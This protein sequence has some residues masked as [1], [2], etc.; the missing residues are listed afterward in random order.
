MT[1]EGIL[2]YG[3]ASGRTD[4]VN[5]ARN[6]FGQAQLLHGTR[7]GWLP[8]S[9]SFVH[10]QGCETDTMTAQTEMAFLLARKVDDA[11]WE[12]AEQIALNQ[13]LAQQLR[14]VDFLDD[15]MRLLGGFASFCSPHDWSTPEGPYITQSSHGSG[16]RSLYNVWYHSAWWQQGDTPGE[17]D[18][19][20]RINLHWSKNL[21]DAR[22]ISYLP[23]ST[24][25]EVYLQRPCHLVIRKPD[26]APIGQITAEAWPSSGGPPSAVPIILNGRWMN[27]GYFSEDVLVIINFPDEVVF[28]QDII[29]NR[30]GG[31]DV[32]YTYDTWWRGNAVLKIEP[33][34]VKQPNYDGRFNPSLPPYLP[35]HTPRYALDPIVMTP[36]ENTADLRVPD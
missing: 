34:G 5:W 7:F 25:M 10:G 16:M 8:E 20:L 21:P 2:I 17:Q 29:H 11:Y 1:M 28:H 14:R 22:I 4:L 19:T 3:L 15:T 33:N 12:L 6:A 31:G 18:R 13:L 36:L 26:W 32:T 23:A 24:K 27:L 9:L 35:F 30:S